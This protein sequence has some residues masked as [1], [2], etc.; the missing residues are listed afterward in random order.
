[1]TRQVDVTDDDSVTELVA[2]IKEDGGEISALFNCAVLLNG[3]KGPERNIKSIDKEFFL[4]SFAINAYGP[5]NTSRQILPLLS[6]GGTIVNFSARVGSIADDEMGGW[7]SYRCSK[8][9]LNHI[10]KLMHIEFNRRGH[11][12][13]FLSVHPGTTYTPMSSPFTQRRF[14]AGD[15]TLHS[16]E[17]TAETIAGL[18]AG[19]NEEHSGGFFDWSGQSLPF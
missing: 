12:A 14:E 16:A 9:A 13:N 3:D 5:I 4:D 11:K 19:A 17:F 15:E 8:S 10:T 18:V 6:K 1:M 7:W 2:L